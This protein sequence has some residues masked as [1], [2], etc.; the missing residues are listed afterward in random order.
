M[1]SASYASPPDTV[2]D[3]PPVRRDVA[4]A[5]TGPTSEV[6]VARLRLEGRS[7]PRS[8]PDPWAS[9]AVFLAE[10][11]RLTVE[12]GGNPVPGDI[13]PR[14]APPGPLP[15]EAP[16]DAMPLSPYLEERL[17]LAH[18][19]MAT[20][21]RE[22]STLERR[23]GVV[24]AAAEHLDR[25]LERAEDE[26]GFLGR[27]AAV[28][29]AAEPIAEGP[30][31]AGGEEEAPEARAAV[32]GDRVVPDD[33]SLPYLRFSAD[34]YN[35]TIGA[36]KFRRRRLVGWTVGLAVAISGALGTAAFLAHEPPP[37]P[38]LAILPLV[39]LVPVPFFVVSFLATHRV[40]RRNHLDVPA[41]A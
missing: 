20:L 2:P 7:P 18:R 26:A 24:R 14:V 32:E 12:L 40:L 34:R 29:L 5:R 25:E 27:L 21:G 6:R 13:R 22:L 39:W 35:R 28:P 31:R 16:P 19:A 30:V 33:G 37:D 41:V 38:W 3:G 23:W 10:L 1:A 36:L 9:P 8:E 4:R 11:D 17:R 15:D